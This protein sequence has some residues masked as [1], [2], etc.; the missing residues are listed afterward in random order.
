MASRKMFCFGLGFSAKCLGL[1][2]LQAGWDVAGTCRSP[3]QAEALIAEDFEAYVFDGDDMPSAEVLEGTTHVLISIPPGTA[4]DP[5]LAHFGEALVALPDL[6]WLGYLS[7]T[8]VYG[9]TDGKWVDES[10]PVQ[11]DV[12]RSQDRAEAEQG[13]LAHHEAQGLPVHIFRLAGIYG[14]G[15]NPLVRIRAGKARR[16]VKPGHQFSRIHVED[17]ANVLEAS[18]AKP[19]PGAIYN[20]CDDEP[21]EPGIITEFGCQLL[22]VEPPPPTPFEDA[23]KGMTPMGLSFWHDNRR[24]RNDRIKSELGVR[25]SYPTYREGLRALAEDL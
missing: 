6:E 18:I 7:T 13:W 24:V 23:A 2:L 4:G 1:R 21:E 9:N 16:I 10:A 19:N 8:G 25:L 22:G 17:I 11:A 15:R 12:P 5:A 3:V 20:V 14:P